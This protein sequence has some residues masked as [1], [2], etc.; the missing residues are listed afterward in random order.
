M[1]ND[2]NQMTESH[3]DDYAVDNNKIFAILPHPLPSDKYEFI[4]KNS[5]DG[6]YFYANKERLQQFSGSPQTINLKKHPL[7]QI[8]G[9]GFGFSDVIGGLRDCASEYNM[10]IKIISSSDE[11]H[12]ILDGYY[13]ENAPKTDFNINNPEELAKVKH[14]SSLTWPSIKG[15][16]TELAAQLEQMGYITEKVGRSGFAYRNSIL[17]KTKEN[18]L[19]DEAIEIVKQAI[20]KA[21]AEKT[22]QEE[23][24]FVHQFLENSPDPNKTYAIVYNGGEGNN[25]QIPDGYSAIA[26][27]RVAATQDNRQG[28]THK[29]ATLFIHDEA[30]KNDKRRQL[31]FVVPKEMIGQIIGKNGSR[32]KDLG[33][34]YNKFFKVE[35]SSGEKRQE[36]YAELKSKIY[37]IVRSHENIDTMAKIN[38]LISQSSWLSSE[39]RESILASAA[40]DFE[41]YK[42]VRKEQEAKNRERSLNSLYYQIQGSFGEKL[43]TTNDEQIK[44]GIASYLQQNKEDLPVVPT[45]EELKQ[46]MEKIR[47][48]RNE[49]IKYQ[50]QKQQDEIKSMKE[51]ILRSMEQAARGGTSFSQKEAGEYIKQTFAESPYLQM[52]LEVGQKE[53]QKYE[54][55]QHIINENSKNIDKVVGEEI[56]KFLNDPQK[57]GSHGT[58]FFFAVGKSR[59]NEAYNSIAYATGKRLNLFQDSYEA[60]SSYQHPDYKEFQN[61]VDKVKDISSKPQ[62]VDVN[63]Y[64]INPGMDDSNNVP[65]EV[66]DAPEELTPE[67][68]A[69]RKEEL[70]KVK[71]AAKNGGKSKKIEGGLS[72]LAALLAQR[73]K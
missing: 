50:E 41:A 1:E 66:N 33:K 60:V 27:V 22:K 39:E 53:V 59:R 52:L 30:M 45:V 40:K 2:T 7:A 6:L 36:Q 65:E 51:N 42:E 73:E 68:R 63:D 43:L 12:Y 20:S 44:L 37:N 71:A 48:F 16:E 57:T 62:T 70:K 3:Y 34:Q 61:L 13:K 19:D 9:V 14:L 46:M 17:I 69:A 15:S 64:I 26:E 55:K 24:S 21:K 28:Y 54:E 4:A 49:Q 25:I 35:Q 67:E 29:Y 47:S 5:K 8:K 18:V 38:E 10:D 58:D 32:I 11:H 31:T 72:G 23:G 56:D